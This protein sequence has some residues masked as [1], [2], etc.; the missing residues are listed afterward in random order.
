MAACCRRQGRRPG[1]A[2]GSRRCRSLRRSR[3]SAAP[4]RAALG[5]P[6][7]P[8]WEGSSSSAAEASPRSTPGCPRESGLS[9]PR[10]SWQPLSARRSRPARSAD[11]S[12]A[13]RHQ[14]ASHTSQTRTADFRGSDRP[15]DTHLLPVADAPLQLHPAPEAQHRPVG[16]VTGLCHRS[17][18]MVTGHVRPSLRTRGPRWPAGAGSWAP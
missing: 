12:A 10:R 3:L 15:A 4:R 1:W 8:P 18:A 2:A 7:A 5:A 14:W 6:A 9:W 16:L 11:R 13:V 17:V